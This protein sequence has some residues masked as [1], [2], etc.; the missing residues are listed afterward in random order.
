M[1]TTGENKGVSS[2]LN[3]I[4]EE[5]RRLMRIPVGRRMV[6]KL[7]GLAALGMATA[8]FG[9]CSDDGGGSSGGSERP[10]EVHDLYFTQGTSAL[11]N[12]TLHAGGNLYSLET[13]TDLDRAELASQGGFYGKMDT[14]RLSHVARNVDLPGDRPLALFVTGPTD[15]GEGYFYE[16]IHVP[17]DSAVTAWKAALQLAG[18][19]SELVGDCNWL[20]ELGIASPNELSAEDLAQLNVT[21]SPSLI[22]ASLVY[23]HPEIS[24]LEKDSS[25]VTM[26]LL[27]SDPGV[28]D[29]GAL[30]AQ[31]I[32]Q[33]KPYA[34][35]VPVL[36]G[37][38]N[39]VYITNPTTGDK[40]Q[41]FT[42]E[43]STD[44]TDRF[45]RAV[46]LCV[47]DVKDCM[48]LEGKTWNLTP[49]TPPEPRSTD[50]EDATESDDYQ[51]VIQWTG[52]RHGA[53]VTHG[54]FDPST[55]QIPIK[56]Y[57]N[58]VRYLG[59]FVQYLDGQGERIPPSG[60]SK[61]NT[62]YSQWVVDVQ[63]M[64]TIY[65][66]PFMQDHNYSEATLTLPSNASA[67]RILMCGLGKSPHGTDW[68]DFFPSD[69]YPHR[70]NPDECIMPIVMTS[71][72]DIGITLMFLALDVSTTTFLNCVRKT[73][74]KWETE[75][76][77]YLADIK[78][79]FAA[80]RKTTTLAVTALVAG[81]AATTTDLMKSGGSLTGSI[82]GDLLQ[83]GKVIP[84]LISLCGSMQK[85]LVTIIPLMDST[86]AIP[87]IGEIMAAMAVAG[88][89]A[90]LVET[91]AEV[92]T[93]PW[94]I[95]NALHVTYTATVTIHHDPD[96]VVFPANR[97]Q[98]A[99][100]PG[101]RRV[102]KPQ[103]HHRRCDA[104]GNPQRTHRGDDYGRAHQRHHP[105]PGQ[106]HQCARG[107]GGQWRQRQ[108][109]QQ[110][111]EQPAP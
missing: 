69:A 55:R 52:Y 12:L 8:Q 28:S 65:G 75:C 100:H 19:V 4:S 23:K 44:L 47:N 85:L 63:D 73:L 111:R 24:S 6:L 1:K 57:N 66:V 86:K 50:A 5:L 7:G 84:R 32:E 40:I 26:T 3:D 20:E 74:A 49:G 61:R 51:V 2:T 25:A 103:S 27:L 56:I 38:G 87:I 64:P 59:V 30:I 41:A 104:G 18:S 91:S 35:E 46:R 45:G 99:T 110:R 81:G 72:F 17:M 78:D 98:L 101:D 70:I 34:T 79:A 14:S 95:K 22:A 94:V 15:S 53:K 107:T 9:G 102:G 76:V 67:A 43:I 97:H 96:D 105:V 93:S 58:Y 33:G 92:A 21:V 39:P 48:D 31:M 62:D 80:I 10:R 36:D 90:R 109:G 54:D 106:L 68:R 108:T 71:V 37:D 89:T 60:T 82:W 29:L 13:M 88:D 11:G 42:M 16:T 77:P 83:L